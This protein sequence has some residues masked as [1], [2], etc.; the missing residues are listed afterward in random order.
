M[1]R[2]KS[3]SVSRNDIVG[4]DIFKRFTVCK[5]DVDDGVCPYSL[6]FTFK[7]GPTA[8]I[9]SSHVYLSEKEVK[10]LL[11]ALSILVSAS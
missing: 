6:S 3:F 11:L 5:S 4:P 1:E 7:G 2:E 8:P 10:D 9:E